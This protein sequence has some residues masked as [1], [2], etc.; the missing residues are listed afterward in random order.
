MIFDLHCDTVYEIRKAKLNAKSVSLKKSNLQIDE[1]KLLSGNYM[2][3]C[4]AIWANVREENPYRLSKQL[5]KTYYKELEGCNEI[6][7]ALSYA[8]ILKNR[9]D[10]KIS[11]ILTLEDGAPLGKD[12]DRLDEFINLG[13]RMICLVWNYPN[14]IAYPNFTRYFSDGARGV[15]RPNEKE[16]L[17]KFGRELVRRMNKLG[18]IVDVSHISD[19]GFFEV[20]DI[21]EKPIVAS[22]SNAR[23]LCPHPRNLSDGM[24]RKIAECCGVIGINYEASF[25]NSDKNLGAKTVPRVTEHVK[26]IGNLI[27]YDYIALGSD[28]DGIGR[29]IELE[30]ASDLPK[31]ITFLEKEGFADNVIEKITCQNALRVFRDC[32]N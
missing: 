15:N 23:A 2:A 29:N 30:Y 24:L 25:L 18:V 26:Y 22:H 1:G 16:G 32:I 21:S 8:D 11:A 27:G 31:L 13:V 19:A 4:F 12:M 7:P 17:T 20:A 5:I 14:D 3:Q 10:G 9:E 6:Y 28:F